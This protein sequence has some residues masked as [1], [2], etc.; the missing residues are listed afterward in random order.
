MTSI[1]IWHLEQTKPQESVLSPCTR[2]YDLY[3]LQGPNPALSRF[4]Y[5]LVGSDWHWYMRLAW[6]WQQWMDFLDRDTV[7]TWVAYLK[8]QPVGYFE[9]ELA[10]A[11]SVE[12]CYFG[13]VPDFIGKGMG[14][15][16][17][18]DAINKAW[19]LG[20]RRVWLHTCTLDHPSA[21]PNYKARGFKVF[22]IEETME[23]IPD[24]PLQPWP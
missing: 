13:L 9:L 3:R 2:P 10:E 24:E 19:A 6:N 23:D 1:K 8:G 12:I 18:E 16:L 11:G 15:L 21:L 14:K 4:L 22:R 17:L 5:V 7:E 20:G